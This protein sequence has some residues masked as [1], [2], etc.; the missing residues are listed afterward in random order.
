MY[1]IIQHKLGQ[2]HTCMH[3][4]TH[5]ARKRTGNLSLITEIQWSTSKG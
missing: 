5:T 1:K 2:T 4:Y 3:V